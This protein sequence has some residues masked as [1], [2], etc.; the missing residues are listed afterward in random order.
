MISSGDLSQLSILLN[1]LGITAGGG[2]GG[3]VTAQQVQRS[4]FNF[5]SATGA[6]DAFVVNLF[7]AVTSLTDGLLITM[8]SGSL[9]NATTSPTLQVN[10]LTPVP[11]VLWSGSVAV[12]DIQ[13]DASYIFVY[14]LSSNTFELI[15]PS[16]STANTYLTQSNAYNSAIDT[17]FANSYAVTLSPAPEGSFGVGFPLYMQVGV[18]NTNTGGSTLDVNGVAHNIVLQDGSSLPGG[19]L[20]SGQ[21]AYM[22]FCNGNW[23]LMNPVVAALGFPWTV[24]SGNVQAALINNGY[25]IGNA[26][27]TLVKM[28]TISAV[29][30]II[31]IRG[32]GAGGWILAMP[33]GGILHVGQMATTP[34][35]FVTSANN[36]DSIDVICI[37]ADTEWTINSTTSSGF[38]VS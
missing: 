1:M 11:I 10:A 22:L 33:T 29:G 16:I 17:G 23:V 30:S 34:G 37:V 36:Y 25:I 9:V 27:Q 13:T 15:N 18:G 24:V 8:S 14:S 31:S 12:G 5:I 26:A 32:M 35:G 4:S 28:P 21:I 6:N 38:I 7:P 3:G 20:V 19:V 2:G